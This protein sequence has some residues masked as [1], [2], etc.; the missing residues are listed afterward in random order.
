MLP[1]IT[2][3]KEDCDMKKIARTITGL[4]NGLGNVSWVFPE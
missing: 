1:H 4:Y 2:T 3:L